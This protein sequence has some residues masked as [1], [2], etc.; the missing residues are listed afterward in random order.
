MDSE[1]ECNIDDEVEVEEFLEGF[2]FLS[3]DDFEELKIRYT[4]QQKENA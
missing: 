1:M 3:K 2:G 4:K